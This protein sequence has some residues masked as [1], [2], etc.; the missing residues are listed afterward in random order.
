MSTPAA[1]LR[2]VAADLHWHDADIIAQ[3]GEGG[4]ECRS[5]CPLDTVLAFHH[6]SL[7]A[8]HSSAEKVAIAD[9]A[10]EWI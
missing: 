7:V 10:E 1:A 5:H 6:Q 9:L 4:V 3:A 2:H 8:E